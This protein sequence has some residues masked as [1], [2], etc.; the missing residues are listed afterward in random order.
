MRDVSKRFGTRRGLDGLSLSVDGGSVFGFL[1]PNGAGK[2]TTLR[3]LL[4]LLRPDGGA[5]SV[6][7][8]D[9]LRESNRLRAEI[10][11]LLEHDGLYG[12]LSAEYNLRYYA[13]INHVGDEVAARRS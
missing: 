5:V 9:P 1:G 3:A 11:V 2:T 12:R 6:L 13:R 8:R 4:G 10:G 7:G